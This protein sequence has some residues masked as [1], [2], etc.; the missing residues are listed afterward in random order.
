MKLINNTEVWE[1]SECYFFVDQDEE[2]FDGICVCITPIQYW[3]EN[4]YL[5]DCFGDHSLSEEIVEKLENADIT[6]IMEATWST[7]GTVEA[8]REVMLALGF[9][10]SKDMAEQVRKTSN[11]EE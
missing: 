10:E 4:R 7:E 3:N 5:D 6:N 9:V 11:G 1:P 2:M 8:A